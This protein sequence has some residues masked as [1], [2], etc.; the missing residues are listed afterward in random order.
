ME[1]HKIQKKRT[2][3]KNKL[4]GQAHW[5][6]HMCSSKCPI[7]RSIPV[8][9]ANDPSSADGVEI[10]PRLGCFA[11]NLTPSLFHPR[12]AQGSTW[13][14]PDQRLRLPSGG[15]CCILPLTPLPAPLPHSTP[16]PPTPRFPPPKPQ[17]NHIPSTPLHSPSP[18]HPQPQPNPPP[19]NPLPGRQS[20]PPESAEVSRLAPGDLLLRLWLG[21]PVAS[22]FAPSLRGGQRR[23]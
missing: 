8:Q 16:L 6:V 2:K 7:D 4:R 12:C 18:P 11:T 23:P 20:S 10:G 17:P 14:S 1:S 19:R 5:T 22:V 21:R 15:I 13:K 3:N 9:T